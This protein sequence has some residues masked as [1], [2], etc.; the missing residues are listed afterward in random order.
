MKPKLLLVDGFNLFYANYYTNTKQ[1]QNGEPI[2]GL[3]GFLNQL[4]NIISKFSPQQV[5]V[6]FDGPNAGYR[7]RQEFKEYKGKRARKERCARIPLSE[8]GEEKDEIRVNNE[9]EQL[10]KLFEILKLLPV[11][12]A[13]IAYYEADDVIGHLAVKNAIESKVI[14]VSSD[15][16][17]L[18]LINNNVSCYQ[19]FKQR[20]ITLDNFQETYNVPQSNYLFL[21]TICGDTS[22]AFKGV[23]GISNKTLIKLLPEIQTINFETFE[24]FWNTIKNIEGE[25]KTIIKLKEGYNDS[26]DTF[27]LMRLGDT[28][29]LKAIE[30]LKLQLKEQEYK[31][32]SKLTFKV[33]C[34]KNELNREFSNFEGWI[35]P[36]NFLNKTSLILQ[37]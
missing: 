37:A 34:A 10:K 17:Y 23:K 20:L 14:I 13:I 33:Y 25:S 1:N 27:K 30:S 29:N 19:P 5:V 35:N 21:R 22:D 9:E 36:F 7:R 2:G 4:R 8:K 24:E 31:P 11:K 15:K 3:L 6:I 28:L 26:L 12:L 32:Y 16:D 18:Q